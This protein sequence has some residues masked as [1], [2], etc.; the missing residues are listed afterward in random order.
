M[1]G[2]FVHMRRIH[3]LLRWLVEMTFAPEIDVDPST[4]GASSHPVLIN[5]PCKLLSHFGGVLLTV[6]GIVNQSRAGASRVVVYRV[7]MHI[8][9]RYRIDLTN[10]DSRNSSDT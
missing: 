4:P 8:E 3:V 5:L 1:S 7:H 6:V 10:S 2:R 9:R